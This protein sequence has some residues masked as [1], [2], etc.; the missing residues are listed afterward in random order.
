VKRYETD[1]IEPVVFHDARVVKADDMTT[2]I[3]GAVIVRGEA[4]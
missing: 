4:E 2:Q 3:V 1:G